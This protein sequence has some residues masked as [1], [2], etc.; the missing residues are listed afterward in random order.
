MC[1]FGGVAQSIHI[2]CIIFIDNI[3]INIS[4]I[5][6]QEVSLLWNHEVVAVSE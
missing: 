2:L 5:Y 1:A 3:Y 4:F 6:S